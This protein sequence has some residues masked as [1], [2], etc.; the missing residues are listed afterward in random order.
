MQ[1]T[2]SSV[3]DD[4]MSTQTSNA[5]LATT[6]RSSVAAPIKT[7]A[8]KKPAVAPKK[9]NVKG[10]QKSIAE[11]ATATPK[12][13]KHVIKS[14]ENVYGLNSSVDTRSK[15]AVQVAA[16]EDNIKLFREQLN[17]HKAVAASNKSLNKGSTRSIAQA[18]WT[19]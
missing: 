13:R 11:R 1:S 10:S 16:K 3:V 8:T 2:R 4:P 5:N 9:P 15:K 7:A 17:L 18:H 14:N 12:S 6:T 19:Y